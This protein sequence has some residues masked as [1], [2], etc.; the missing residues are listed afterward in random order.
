MSEQTQSEQEPQAEMTY[1]LKFL[2]DSM[3]YFELHDT[4]MSPCP[5]GNVGVGER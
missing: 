5:Q 4:G 3:Q 2:G 1:H